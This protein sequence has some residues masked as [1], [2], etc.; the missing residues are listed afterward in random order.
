MMNLMPRAVL[1]LPFPLDS[2]VITKHLRSRLDAAALNRFRRDEQNRVTMVGRQVMAS[3]Q[4]AGPEDLVAP[5]GPELE[6]ILVFMS[7]E[8][9]RLRAA[10]APAPKGA[11]GKLICLPRSSAI[12]VWVIP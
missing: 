1:Y 2:W 4:A 3:R 11:K 7:G 5:T 6:E 9:E 8:C 10:E 12:R